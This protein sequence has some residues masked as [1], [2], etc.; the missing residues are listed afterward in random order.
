MH[1]PHEVQSCELQNV[2]TSLLHN[3]CHTFAGLMSSRASIHQCL[4]SK[5]QALKVF[6]N[7]WSV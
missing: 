2:S 6:S 5:R 4:E 3:T 7:M 1:T